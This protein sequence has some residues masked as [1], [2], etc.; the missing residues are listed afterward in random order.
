MLLI[1]GKLVGNGCRRLFGNATTIFDIIENILEDE[2]KIKKMD[3]VGMENVKVR[4]KVTRDAMILFDGFFSVLQ[5]TATK[6]MSES[7][8][9]TKLTLAERYVT[10][11]MQLWRS[12]QMSVTPKAHACEAHAT[13]KKIR[14]TEEWVERLHQEHLRDKV[15]VRSMR[16]K[17][18][19][20]SHISRWE[21]A[22][23]SPKIKQLV[24]DIHQRRSLSKE[25]KEKRDQTAKRK[26]QEKSGEEQEDNKRMR[27]EEERKKIRSDTLETYINP[28]DKLPTALQEDI[29]ESR[30]V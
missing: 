6:G 1:G 30:L 23:R 29:R 4:C 20:F 25:T 14:T 21:Q 5:E 11:A 22:N 12:L 16:D 19:R 24:I 3:P 10:G 26:R 15:R 8:L 28:D 27:T 2:A 18:K 9:K 13:K 7:E 17:A